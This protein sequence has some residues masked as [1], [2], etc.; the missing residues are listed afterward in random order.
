MVFLAQAISFLFG[1]FFFIFF[2]SKRERSKVQIATYSTF[3]TGVSILLSG[4]APFLP[5]SI[6]LLFIGNFLLGLFI[7]PASSI[8]FPLIKDKVNEIFKENAKD[9]ENIL[10]SL[11]NLS[12]Q[13][14]AFAGRV[15]AQYITNYVGFRENAMIIG[16]LNIIL[17]F[18]YFIFGNIK[19]E[20][21]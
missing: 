1:T 15:F 10:S 11:F 16:F 18:V 3:F 5:D 8:A 20:F 4:P 9:F 19:K 12:Y 7:A 6:A 21:F 2:V 14:G 17:V 13:I